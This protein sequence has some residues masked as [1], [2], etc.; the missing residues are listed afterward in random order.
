MRNHYKWG[1]QD[2]EH[3]MQ[4]SLGSS[5]MTHLRQTRQQDITPLQD[6]RKVYGSCGGTGLGALISRHM[7]CPPV[8]APCSHY[9]LSDQSVQRPPQL[10][11]PC[12]GCSMHLLKAWYEPLV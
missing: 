8:Q 4:P 5:N 12:T 9:S 3:V 10:K 11:H 6:K 2:W 7:P 1:T